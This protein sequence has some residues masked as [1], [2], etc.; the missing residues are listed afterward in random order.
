MTII[1]LGLY[2]PNQACILQPV[3]VWRVSSLTNNPCA[4]EH[5]DLYKTNTLGN[6]ERAGPHG[7]TILYQQL[8]ILHADS[9][10]VLRYAK[11][12]IRL[13]VIFY[14]SFIY[15]ILHIVG[16]IYQSGYS[17]DQLSRYSTYKH[18]QSIWYNRDMS[19]M[20][21]IVSSAADIVHGAYLMPSRPSLRL[22]GRPQ[23]FFKSRGSLGFHPIF[24][25]YG[26]NVH[27]NI[28]PK[29]CG[30]RISIFRSLFFLY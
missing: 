13:F 27:S 11:S 25:I 26:L 16:Y 14:L 20:T 15:I 7:H 28:V 3:A 24:L 29:N 2:W 5:D 12:K 8:L 23:T 1:T 6:L 21:W 17:L 9:R 19:Y 18:Q 22:S 30:I 4:H 10:A